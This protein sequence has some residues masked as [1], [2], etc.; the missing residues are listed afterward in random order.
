MPTLLEKIEELVED[1]EREIAQ[2]LLEKGSVY[3]R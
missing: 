3:A 2:E 1:L